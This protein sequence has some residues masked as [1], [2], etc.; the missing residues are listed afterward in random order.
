MAPTVLQL[1]GPSQP[2][3]TISSS[4][5]GKQIIEYLPSSITQN[6]YTFSTPAKGIII[7]EPNTKEAP[8]DEQQA[9][10]TRRSLE[11]ELATQEQEF[12]KKI[13]TEAAKKTDN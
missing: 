8:R 9:R 2:T 12:H 5:T 1:E 7:K 4:N 13:R 3:D 6:E 11:A 10:P